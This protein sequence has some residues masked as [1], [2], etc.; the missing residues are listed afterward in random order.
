M[1]SEH[2]SYLLTQSERIV[3]LQEALFEARAQDQA[4]IVDQ[5]LSELEK[6][7]DDLVG[8]LPQLKEDDWTF[9]QFMLGSLCSTMELW[10]HAEQAYAMALEHWPDHVGLLNEMAHCQCELGNYEKAI[11]FYEQSLSIGGDDPDIH[12]N[13]T[14]A[15]ALSGAYQKATLHA[16]TTLARHPHHASLH[17]VLSIL[18]SKEVPTSGKPTDP[19]GEGATSYHA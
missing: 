4:S 1:L 8:L 11:A 18:E 14:M 13:I 17:E 12:Y 6:I 15:L 16:I 9:A 7:G 3:D 5:R 2:K 19:S 10:T